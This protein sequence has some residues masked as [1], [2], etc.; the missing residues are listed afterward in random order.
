M[1][2]AFFPSI[3]HSFLNAP[4]LKS[5]FSHKSDSHN[6][7]AGANIKDQR[8]DEMLPLLA[9]LSLLA[10]F[11]ASPPITASCASLPSSASA[12]PTNNKALF[13]SIDPLTAYPG[14]PVYSLAEVAKHT[15]PETGGIWIAAHG[16]VY[17]VTNFISAHPG[18]DKILLARGASAEPFWALYPIHYESK[19]V[20]SMLDKYRIG[21]LAPE[22]RARTKA[23]AAAG[24]PFAQ[25]PERHPALLVLSDKPFNAASPMELLIDSY[26]TPAPL[27]FTRHHHPVPVVTEEDYRLTVDFAPEIRSKHPELP[28]ARVFTLAELKA[29]FPHTDVMSTI[30]CAGNR[31]SELSA[32]EPTDGL[33]WHDGALSN[34]LWRGARLRDIARAMGIQDEEHARKTLGVTDVV[35][36]AYDDPFDASIPVEK[37]VSSTG[38]V[39]MAW[40]MNGEELPRDHGYPLR[41]VV[42]GAVGVRNVKWVK[43]ITFAPEE[44]KSVWQRGAP[45][46]GFAPGVKSFAGIDTHKIPSVQALPVMSALVVP[47]PGT[48]VQCW[49]PTAPA[50]SGANSTGA[51]TAAAAAE[52]RWE[53]SIE[54]RGWAYSGGGAGIVRVDVTADDGA[55]WTTAEITD[56]PSRAE[57]DSRT[58]WAWSLWRADVP[59]PAH[60]KPGDTVTVAVKAVDGNYNQQPERPDVVWNRRGILNNSWHKVKVVVSEDDE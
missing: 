20:P 23:A 56:G 18:G 2:S 17:D 44:A 22:D 14:L 6:D 10:A 36:T 12:G 28:P 31:R 30:V 50:A 60:A 46:K 40:G 16:C 27:F 42:P 37:G 24:D 7:N 41:V 25:D 5:L 13:D 29:A 26:I 45:Y 55:N 47:K 35:F 39:L 15:S 49:R 11:L 19:L 9:L 52:D 32:I 48:K 33:A 1:S 59:L 8:R 4:A 58:A 54:A 57:I 34:G 3:K 21:V 51:A 43:G 53:G 38:H